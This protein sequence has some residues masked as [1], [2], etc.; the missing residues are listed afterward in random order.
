MYLA[1]RFSVTKVTDTGSGTGRRRAG[2]EIGKAA[3]SQIVKA[4][5]NEAKEVGL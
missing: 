4:A 2:D 3:W 5:V 1:E